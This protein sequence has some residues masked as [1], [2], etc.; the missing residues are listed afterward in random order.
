[1]VDTAREVLG[2]VRRKPRRYQAALVSEDIAVKLTML[3]YQ[4]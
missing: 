1:V 3:D 4:Q 2:R